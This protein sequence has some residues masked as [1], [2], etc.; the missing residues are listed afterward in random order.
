M[1]RHIVR[2]N[3]VC[4]SLLLPIWCCMPLPVRI[5][6]RCPVE[7][8]RASHLENLKL[9]C[10][11]R[12]GRHKSSFFARTGIRRPSGRYK[13]GQRP[14]RATSKQRPTVPK[15][16]SLHL[17]RRRLR[18]KQSVAMPP[19]TLP[20]QSCE[21]EY[22]SVF[23]DEICLPSEHDD[24]EPKHERLKV[25]V[26]VPTVGVRSLGYRTHDDAEILQMWF[27][28]CVEKNLYSGHKHC[29]NLY[30]GFIA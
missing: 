2:L 1:L 4:S 19:P 9:C 13:P 21:S 5:A 16:P 15:P 23:L 14:S 27:D 10:R 30:N 25:P 6:P 24:C 20:P 29:G 3:D 18:G 22:E 12:S 28:Q 26:K 17:P 7:K 8:R 11:I